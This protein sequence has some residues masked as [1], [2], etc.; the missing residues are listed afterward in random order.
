MPSFISFL[1]AE[2]RQR[3]NAYQNRVL[4]SGVNLPTPSL[5]APAPSISHIICLSRT[6][7]HLA[8]L[9]AQAYNIKARRIYVFWSTQCARK[10]MLLHRE[11]RRMFP[12]KSIP[13]TAAGEVPTVSFLL[14]P[15]PYHPRCLLNS[16]STLASSPSH[17]FPPP[18]QAKANA[19]PLRAC[20]QKPR[21]ANSQNS[22]I[23][24]PS[25]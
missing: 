15:I 20:C 16:P 24:N 21:Q 17:P 9:L 1:I 3:L 10:G 2:V 19:H 11:S 22:A 25:T 6:H 14:S 13:P 12:F 7:L 8:I 5:D 4:L 23:F 18:R